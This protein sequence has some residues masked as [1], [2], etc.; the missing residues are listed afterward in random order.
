MIQS[1]PTFIVNL[2]AVLLILLSGAALV[3]GIGWSAT[4]AIARGDGKSITEALFLSWLCAFQF[5]LPYILTRNFR[6]H[7]DRL[8]IVHL[9]GLVRR[10]YAYDTLQLAGYR[11]TT[12]G[13]V[14]QKTNGDQVTLGQKQYK[15]YEELR[16]VLQEKIR[17]GP[18]R[19]RFTNKFM[20]RMF[21]FGAVLMVAMIVFQA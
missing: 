17:E 1:K 19:L 11:Y 13:V 6:L 8:E 5:A 7:E 3:L 14:I 15:N 21:W 4:N 20:R 2:F 16:Q 10:S 9:F 18:L 12:S